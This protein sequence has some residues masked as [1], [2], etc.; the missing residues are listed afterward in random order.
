MLALFSRAF[1][2][3]GRRDRETASVSAVLR[4]FIPLLGRRPLTECVQ[5]VGTL[6]LTTHSSVAV[7]RFNNETLLL[8]ITPKTMTVIARARLENKEPDNL[9]AEMCEEVNSR[10]RAAALCD[11]RAER[12]SIR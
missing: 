5:H 9:R 8:G 12:T 7:I 6:P 11:R 4:R 2:W 3:A 1:G 10:E